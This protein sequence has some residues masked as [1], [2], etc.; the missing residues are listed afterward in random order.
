MVRRPARPTQTGSIQRAIVAPA[1]FW[2]GL[3]C[4]AVL[5]LV[6]GCSTYSTSTITRPSSYSSAP[7]PPG[8]AS[9]SRVVTASWYGN[10]LNGHRT[11]NGEI[12][13]PNGLTAASPSLPIG[14]H[15][16]VTNVSNGRT[17]VVR[18]NDRGPYVK[19]RSIDLSHAAAEQIGLT[20]KGVGQVEIS[21][22]DEAPGGAIS[23]VSYTPSRPSLTTA[24][25]WSSEWGSSTAQQV[26]HRRY[27]HRRA[28]RRTVRNPIEHWVMSALPRL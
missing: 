25:W 22:P 15:V 16:A 8:P 17:V 2:S 4:V 14:S 21:R 27:H 5:L 19:G 1:P 18:I 23:R 3:V 28:R 7:L 9:S 10:E 11:S 20:R 12:F 13:D 6:S 24:R 26:H